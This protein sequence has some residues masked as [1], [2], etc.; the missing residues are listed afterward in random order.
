MAT[1]KT[2]DPSTALQKLSSRTEWQA[3][4][5][6]VVALFCDHFLGWELS[7]ETI[8]GIVALVFSYALSRGVAKR[9]EGGA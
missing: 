1:R 8:G 2:N 5:G 9:G 4:L 3:F 6:A 7:A